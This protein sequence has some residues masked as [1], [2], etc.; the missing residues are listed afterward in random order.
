MVKKLALLALGVVVIALLLAPVALAAAHTSQDIYDDFINHNGK[1][2]GT[3]TKAELKAF[4]NDATFH[5]YHPTRIDQLDDTI[6]Q[7]LNRSTFP[8]TGFQMLIAGIV[9]VALVGGGFAL[10][11]VSRQS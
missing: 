8:F 6:N 7:L 11:R 4:L 5:Q 9:A 10:R 1:L 3:Y 2:T